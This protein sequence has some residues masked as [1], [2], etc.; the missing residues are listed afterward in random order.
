MNIQTFSAGFSI[1]LTSLQVSASELLMVEEKSCYWCERWDQEISAIYPK[2]SA[3]QYAP[4][5]RVGINALPNEIRFNRSVMFTPTFILIDND[6]G[7]ARIEALSWRR[8]FW[9]LL[10]VLWRLTPRSKK[11]NDDETSVYLYVL[12]EACLCRRQRIRRI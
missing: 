6:A 5:R 8:F 10:R 12:G 2:T 9:P 4:L 7:L 11:T 3:G 1:A